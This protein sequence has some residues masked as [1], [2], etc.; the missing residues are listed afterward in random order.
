MKCSPDKKIVI[1]VDGFSSCG[2]STF[3]KKIASALG[4]VFIAT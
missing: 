2:K 3:A 1:A 4:Y